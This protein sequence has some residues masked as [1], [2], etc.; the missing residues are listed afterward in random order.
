MLECKKAPYWFDRRGSAIQDARALPIDRVA[1]VLY[2]E[3]YIDP[4]HGRHDMANVLTSSL[5]AGAC[6]VQENTLRQLLL[7]Y[8]QAKIV[9]V[10]NVI[11][12]VSSV[13]KT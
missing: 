1:V 4:R 7:V 6:T 9:I 13:V 3:L 10:L 2:L 8:G 11:F 12:A 5:L